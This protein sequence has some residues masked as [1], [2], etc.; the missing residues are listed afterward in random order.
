M[1]P[2]LLPLMQ[3]DA[4]LLTVYDSF[5]DLSMAVKTIVGLWVQQA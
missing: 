3:A 5:Q 2:P 4:L 1:Q